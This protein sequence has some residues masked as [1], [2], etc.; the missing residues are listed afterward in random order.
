MQCRFPTIL[1]WITYKCVCCLKCGNMTAPSCVDWCGQQTLW[2]TAV[3][4]V[5]FLLVCPSAQTA[6]K[7]ATTKVTTTTCFVARRGALV[8][9]EMLVLWDL[10]GKII[11][12]TRSFF[13]T[14]I[15]SCRCEFSTV[16]LCS[17]I[18]IK[19]LRKEVKGWNK[20]KSISQWPANFFYGE[21][22]GY[23]KIKTF[24]ITWGKICKNLT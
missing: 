12:N 9:A 24:T 11:C 19:Y 2:H 23:C 14:V 13:C 17:N 7:L 15:V 3:E 22:K 5:A 6:S 10:K 1:T 8:I 16:F 4:L 18:P 21:P 20:Y